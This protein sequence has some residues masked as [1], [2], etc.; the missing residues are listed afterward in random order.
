ML[1]NT[2]HLR[3]TRRSTSNIGTIRYAGIT[4]ILI[5]IITIGHAIPSTT[6]T[7][8]RTSTACVGCVLDRWSST[9][10]YLHTQG[11]HPPFA[12]HHSL[13]SHNIIITVITFVVTLHI[14]VTDPNSSSAHPTWV[15]DSRCVVVGKVRSFIFIFFPMRHLQ[16]CSTVNRLH[17]SR[18]SKS[19]HRHYRPLV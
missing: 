7:I 3:W 1:P 10:W 6:S 17:C 5:T 19:S 18:L 8:Q 12:F 4:I 14:I 16:C 11:F 15:D 2:G 13:A 9:P